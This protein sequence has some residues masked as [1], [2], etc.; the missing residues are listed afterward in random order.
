YGSD[1][2]SGV[3]NFIM[4]KDFEGAQLNS[5]YKISERG[6]INEWQ[7]DG[8]MGASA[9]DGRGN[10][11]LYGAYYNRDGAFQDSRDFSA[12]DF[13]FAAAGRG[14]ATGEAGR[15][16]N[17]GFNPFPSTATGVVTTADPQTGDA[18]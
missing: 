10:V 4:K 14:S 13:S 2:V 7:I 15:F 5:T 17:L 11:T 6:D 9:A 12:V 16:D 18:G 1:A 8:T 3:V